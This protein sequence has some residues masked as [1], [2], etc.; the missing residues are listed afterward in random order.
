MHLGTTWRMRWID[1]RGGCDAGYRYRCCIDLL[2]IA[3]A[4]DG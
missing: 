3:A 2:K 1:R 4:A